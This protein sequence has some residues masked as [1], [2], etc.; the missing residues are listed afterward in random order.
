VNSVGYLEKFRSKLIPEIEF[1]NVHRELDAA[2]LTCERGYFFISDSNDL[3]VA[4]VFLWSIDQGFVPIVAPS[5]WD[6]KRIEKVREAFP[7]SCE[8][9]NGKIISNKLGLVIP[10][11]YK[12]T[13]G[14]FSSGTSG[15]PKI[16]F[17]KVESALQNAQSHADSLG[18][19]KRDLILKTL[20]VSHAFGMIAYIWT[21]IVQNCFVRFSSVFEGWK[22]IERDE[23]LKTIAHLTPTLMRFLLKSRSECKNPPQM[24]SIGSSAAS[25][26]ELE[27]LSRLTRSSIFVT[28]GL[29]EAGPRVTTGEWPAGGLTRSGYIGQPIS[30]V[31]VAILDENG[32]IQKNGSGRLLVRGSSNKINVE[33]DEVHQGYLKTP[34]WAV[35]EADGSIFLSP[36]TPSHFKYR[37][38]LINLNE[39]A[40]QPEGRPKSLLAIA[41]TED[42]I[43]KWILVIQGPVDRV[44]EIDLIGAIDSRYRPFQVKW[45]SSWPTSV[46][47]KLDRQALLLEL[48]LTDQLQ[49][50][51][52]Q[53]ES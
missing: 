38:H 20:P 1:E 32:D 6:S 31:Q 46:L 29:T 3:I 44:V 26:H 39:L 53:S 33:A 11:K 16:S 5:Y 12:G 9:Q 24:I 7:F 22:S 27:D 30:G 4:H 23:R 19:S 49:L 10:G 18:I 37:D 47:G 51:F 14:V 42:Q 52:Y 43:E 36:R 40:R 8:W 35:I 2:C 41:Y 45:V 28:Y 13:Y 50:E 48:G 15:P 17:L 25:P 21:P 34:D